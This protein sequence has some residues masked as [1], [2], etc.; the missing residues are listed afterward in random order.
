M[1]P[2]ETILAR[3]KIYG[4]M[5]FKA[6]IASKEDKILEKEV[7][8]LTLPAQAGQLTLLSGHAPIFGRL[9]EGNIVTEGQCF[10]VK[11]GFFYFDNNTAWVIV[12]QKE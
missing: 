3:Q 10:S 1:L 9:Q 11:E 8:F 5:Q 2:K 6:V 7:E 12:T 4:V